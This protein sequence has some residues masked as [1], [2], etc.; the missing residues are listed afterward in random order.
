MQ[1]A[2]EISVELLPISPL[3]A[4]AVRINPYRV[5]EGYFDTLAQ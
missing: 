1:K 5:P 3:L 4:E 2:S